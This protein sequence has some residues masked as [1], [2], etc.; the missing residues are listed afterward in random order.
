MSEIVDVDLEHCAR[1]A[2]I[3]LTDKAL[4]L[5]AERGF[6]SARGS[7][8]ERLDFSLA[9]V[10]NVPQRA[11]VQARQISVFSAASISGDYASGGELAVIAAENL[12]DRYERADGHPGWVFSLTSTGRIVDAARDLYGHAFILYGLAWAMRVDNRQKFRDAVDRT[13]AFLDASMADPVRGGFWDSLPRHNTYRHQNPH[14]HLFEAYL[15]LYESTGEERFIKRCEDIR[16]LALK[17][18]LLE[19]T[20]FL[21]EV[22]HDDWSVAPSPGCGIVEPG[23]LFEWSWLLYRYQD[24]SGISS[25]S[26]I[27]RMMQMA[28]RH[29]LDTETGRILDQISEQGESVVTSSRSW[30]HAEA[31]KALTLIP[32]AIE[33]SSRRAVHKI[34]RRLMT[35]YCSDSMSGGWQDQ[36][37]EFDVPVRKDIP[38]STLYHIYFALKE[39]QKYSLANRPVAR[40][41]GGLPS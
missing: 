20:G 33:N 30:P 22:F 21:R 38:A 37:D 6:D 10:K 9:V 28:V 5:W 16:R 8:H 24:I 18:F 4:P 34:L 40:V 2:S 27:S 13:V 12:I 17:F 31:L 14:M 1:G 23:H 32:N 39:V 25:E 26:A 29:G 35:L 11:M 19:D 3:W 36:L 7:F 41:S 15:A